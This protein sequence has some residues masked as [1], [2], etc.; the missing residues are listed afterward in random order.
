[1]LLFTQSLSKI[2]K[3]CWATIFFNLLS[4]CWAGFKALGVNSKETWQMPLTPLGSGLVSRNHQGIASRPFGWDQVL[5]PSRKLS[6]LLPFWTW[7][8]WAQFKW[9]VDEQ[10]K[11]AFAWVFVLL[12]RVEIE[13]KAFRSVK[14]F[15]QFWLS[16][17]LSLLSVMAKIGRQACL[18]WMDFKSYQEIQSCLVPG[19]WQGFHKLFAWWVSDDDVC[20]SSWVSGEDEKILSWEYLSFPSPKSGMKGK[21]QWKLIPRTHSLE[22]INI[23][24]ENDWVLWHLLQILASLTALG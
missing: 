23:L 5:E 18:A 15:S 17:L 4:H 10:M 20:L 19:A 11:L 24:K 1:M 8:Y 6:W 21:W 14:F 13:S 3:K 2:R 12:P 22:Q 7:N 9:S 16:Y